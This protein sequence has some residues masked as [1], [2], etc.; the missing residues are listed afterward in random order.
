MKKN[1]IT[2]SEEF[3]LNI[4]WKEKVPLTSLQLLDLS[5]KF[6]ESSSWG[7]NYIHKMLTMLQEK[8]LL[9][10]C[11]FIKEGKRYVRQLKPCITKDEYIA[12]ILEKQGVDTASFAKIAMAFVKNKDNK[13][14]IDEHEKIIAELEQMINN[15]KQST[16]ENKN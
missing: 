1:T 5:K 4:F 9:E 10:V 11:G 13:K 12:D 6:P 16:E 2:D 8:N 14:N 3:L 15:L 7:I